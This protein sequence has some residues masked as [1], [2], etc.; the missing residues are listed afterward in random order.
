MYTLDKLKL[1]Y[2]F[3]KV[4][5]DSIHVPQRTLL[6][7]MLVAYSFEKYPQYILNRS[8][9]FVILRPSISHPT[10]PPLRHIKENNGHGSSFS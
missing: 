3:L 5:E 7:E 10:P 2:I 1:R 8:F 6:V 9:I 4:R